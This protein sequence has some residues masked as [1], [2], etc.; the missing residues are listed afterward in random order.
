MKK[1]KYASGSS[2]AV[3]ILVCFVM[4]AMVS[5]GVLSLSGAAADR[6]LCEKSNEHVSEYYSAFNSAQQ[7]LS[8]LDS[9]LLKAY[10]TDDYFQSAK[11]YI[12]QSGLWQTVSDNPLKVQ[13]KSVINENQYINVIIYIKLP[14]DEDDGFYKIESWQSVTDSRWNEN[15][16]LPVYKG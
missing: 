11:D 6:R 7:Q 3:G 15:N 5:F 4:L 2:G 1:K 9:A 10:E 14:T 8:Q 12:Q 16:Q 13:H